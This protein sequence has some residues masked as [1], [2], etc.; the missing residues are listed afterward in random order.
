MAR[1]W[2][3][4]ERKV[5]RAEHKFI[6]IVSVRRKFKE[7]WAKGKFR[8]L[9]TTYQ[10]FP[11][12]QSQVEAATSHALETMV[13]AGAG[14][15]KTSLLLGRAK[16]L[17]ESGR[18]TPGQLLILAFN[19][20][21]AKELNERAE[22][23]GLEVE[24]S[25]FH[26]FGK[27]LMEGGGDRLQLA[28]TNDHEISH[29]I[30]QQIA[31]IDP[32]TKSG[33]NAVRYFVGQLVPEK[34]IDAYKNLN[35]YT[36]YIKSMPKTLQGEKVKSHGEWL[37]ANYLWTMSVSYVYEDLY[38]GQPGKD[39]GHKPDFHLSG[40]DIYIEYFGI[41]KNGRT[42][43]GIASEDYNRIIEWK[44][45][46]H[47]ANRSTLIELT[48]QDLIE[49]NLTSKLHQALKAQNVNLVRKSNSDVLQQANEIGY[50]GRVIKTIQTF[51]QHARAQ[52]PSRE[53]LKL[54]AKDERSRLFLE[55]FFPIY[56]AYE[57]TLATLKRPDFSDLIHGGADQLLSGEAQIPYTHVMIDEF[58]DISFDRYRLIEAIR[59][60]KPKTEM[61][62]VGDDWQAIYAF[63][64]SDVSIMRNLSRPKFDRKR[65]DLGDTFRMPQS[66]A[67]IAS[68][69]VVKNPS[70]LEKVIRSKFDLQKPV[71]FHWDTETDR[72][73]ESLEKVLA[74]IG[75]ARKDNELELHVLARYRDNLPKESFFQGRWAGPVLLDT[76]HKVKG[77]EADYVIIVDVQQ[78]YRGFP[79]TIEDD[80][81][82]SMLMQ[83]LEEF[84]H[85]EE[86]RL[87][88]VALTRAR[89]EVHVISPADSP[90]AFATEFLDNLVGF[91]VGNPEAIHCPKCHTGFLTQKTGQEGYSCSNWPICKLRTPKCPE[92]S[93]AMRLASVN[94]VRYLCLSHEKFLVP[95]CPKCKFG[96][97]VT[98]HGRFGEFQSCHMWPDTKCPGK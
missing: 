55:L 42:H 76:I 1:F 86:R 12:T 83:G 31:S 2:R 14:S 67:D 44:R 57:E 64:G 7:S 4:V 56:D 34:A 96:L 80:P 5:E 66:L 63:A 92:C 91:H 37:I 51:L 95:N 50:Q 53:S 25:T 71:T 97:L 88:Y 73:E 94:P 75:A 17:L 23:L 93:K 38:E 36:A 30:K 70:Q 85:A 62:Y 28:F 81:V 84:P 49:K 9:F 74:A 24:A 69:F 77:L 82:L 26:K 20:N 47:R 60:T 40:T 48:Y 10:K 21:A 18:A 98:R 15:G 41:D 13:V 52:R 45:G 78:D 46:V 79:S 90:S 61:T 3:N 54:A 35:E 33:D 32:S 58:Q 72:I 39:Q 43:P 27:N 29:F 59:T 22:A 89:K 68:D 19:N 16:Y 65:V 8:E 87:F 6:E 11:L